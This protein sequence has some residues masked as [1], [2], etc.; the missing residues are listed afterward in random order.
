MTAKT[1]EAYALSE[2]NVEQ[3][4]RA[5]IPEAEIAAW[6]RDTLQEIFAGQTR[7]VLFDAYVAYVRPELPSAA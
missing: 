1:Y 7:N 5:G 3:A 6:C 4:V 2:T